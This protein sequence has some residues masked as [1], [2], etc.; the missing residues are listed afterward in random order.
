[1]MAIKYFKGGY[2]Q[3]QVYR[4]LGVSSMAVSRWHRE[5]KSG[6]GLKSRKAPGRP[7]RMSPAQI[8]TFRELC[9]NGCVGF[10]T[11]DVAE[12][13]YREFGIS[14]HFDHIGRLMRGLGIWSRGRRK[15]TRLRSVIHGTNTLK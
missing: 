6:S 12:L 10:K 13:I 2:R 1:M 7:R 3:F 15:I 11:A 9:V 5:W 8:E 14:Y 4:L